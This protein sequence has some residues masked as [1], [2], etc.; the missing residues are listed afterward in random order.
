MTA[1]ALIVC[2]LFS[3]YKQAKPDLPTAVKRKDAKKR[4]K[5]NL[6]A[7][8]QGQPPLQIITQSMF[9]KKKYK[10]VTKNPY[11]KKELSGQGLVIC[12]EWNSSYAKI[13]RDKSVEHLFLNYTLG[14]KC[15]DY[16]FLEQIPPIRTLDITDVHSVGIKSIE[17]QHGL[18]TLS[19][20]MPNANGVDFRAFH[21]LKSVFC[22][23]GK[24]NDTLF[25]CGSIERLYIDDLKVGDKHGID[26]LKKLKDLTIANSNITSL[27]FL[28]NLALLES[29]AITNCKQILSFADISFLE[30]LKRIDIRGVK[31]LHDISFLSNLNSMEIVIIET[32]ALATVKPLD[33]LGNIKALALFGRKM[34]IE[35]KDLSPVNKLKQLS[36]LDIPNRKCYSVKIN[37]HWDWNDFGTR[38]ENWLTEK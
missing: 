23:G 34:T 27:A 14:W 4:G 37:N 1:R 22:Y 28:R 10:L 35:D 31:G 8:K 21:N 32:G 26:R 25:S 3:D 2:G 7:E 5:S 17:R 6:C 13:I 19:L 15:S 16:A 30:N 11:N 33:N 20:N 36:M 18:V 38:R 24:R 12:G 29:L 9:D